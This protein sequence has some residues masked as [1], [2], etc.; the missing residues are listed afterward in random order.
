LLIR[1]LLSRKFDL[2]F[3]ENGRSP[4]LR[5]HVGLPKDV[6]TKQILICCGNLYL[7]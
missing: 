6:N 5:L 2:F 3:V 4:D 1:K 7:Q